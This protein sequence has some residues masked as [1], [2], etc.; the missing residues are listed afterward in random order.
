M[1]PISQHSD[2]TLD[3]L[4][5][6]ATSFGGSPW[7]ISFLDTISLILTFFILVYSMAEIDA[8][9]W[10]QIAQTMPSATHKKVSEQPGFARPKENLA[11]IQQS[12][13]VDLDYLEILLQRRLEKLDAEGMVWLET[14]PDRLV[15]HLPADSFFELAS[16][17]IPQN[18]RPLV[19]S[20]AQSLRYIPNQIAVQGH[21]DPDPI[22]SPL[23]P[24]NWELSLARAQSVAAIFAEAGYSGEIETQGFGDRDFALREENMLRDRRFNLA[25]RVDIVIYSYLPEHDLS[26]FHP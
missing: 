14:F 1:N 12:R 26:I 4:C 10:E 6:P 15:L 20:L 9:K 2:E 7:M 21:A 5:K 13:A 18:T 23:Y 24:S 19:A 25:R 22:D 11:A 8:H 16:A 17:D 3:S